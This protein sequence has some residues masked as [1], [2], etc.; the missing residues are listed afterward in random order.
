MYDNDAKGIS[1]GAGFFMLIAF[2]VAGAILGS[3][4]ASLLWQPLT[5]QPLTSIADYIRNPAYSGAARIVQ[6]VSAVIGF[7]V[8]AL[9]TAFYLN[10]KPFRLLGFTGAVSARQAGLTVLV[11]LACMAVSS[12]L[13]HLGRQLPYPDSWVAYFN[14]LETNY[15]EQVVGIIGLSNWQDYLFSLLI[16][17]FLPA[18]CEETLFRGGLQQFLSRA[19]RNPWLAIVIVSAIFSVVH[20]SGYGFL[21]R[22]FLGI[23]LGAIFHYTGRLWLCILAHFIN[24]AVAITAIY[25]YK[26]KGRSLAEAMQDSTGTYWGLILLLAVIPLLTLLKKSSRETAVN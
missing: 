15:T 22:L 18:L 10:R 26:Q 5:G 21:P 2:T 24:N 9:V 12:S 17:G 11:M 25:I 3:A 7:M 20:L 1:W 23:V 16:L 14:R 8:P 13:G 6:A 4:L 19:I